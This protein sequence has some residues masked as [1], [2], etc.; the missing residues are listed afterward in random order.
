MIPIVIPS[1]NSEYLERINQDYCG[2]LYVDGT[3]INY[4]VVQCE[5]NEYYLDHTFYRKENANG[6]LFIDYRNNRDGDNYNMLIY[7]HA[8]KTGAMFGT[9]SR[10]AWPDFYEKNKNIIY[11]TDEGAYLITIFSAYTVDTDSDAWR[12]SF[13]GDDDYAEW[14]SSIKAASEVKNPIRPTIND[15]IV[16]LTTCSFKF[17]DARFVAHGIIEPLF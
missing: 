16:T 9:L 8:M 17:D 10:Y 13:S 5:D 1:V 2:W 7:G 6:C 3:V 4:P 11:V 12:I 14:L 15:R